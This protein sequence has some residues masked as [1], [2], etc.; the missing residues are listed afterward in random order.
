MKKILCV[1]LF[2]MISLTVA[3][4][5]EDGWEN[6]VYYMN[7]W[8]IKCDPAVVGDTL[9]IRQGTD[10]ISRDAFKDCIGIKKV[11]LPFGIEVIEEGAFD[12]T[13][14][15]NDVRNYKDGML[16]ERDYLLR[17]A[18]NAGHVKVPEEVMYIAVDAFKDADITSLSLP[19][20]VK[21]FD[22]FTF[23]YLDEGTP[24]YYDGDI[25]DFLARADFDL[26]DINIYT[27]AEMFKVI[28]TAVLLIALTVALIVACNYFV[29]E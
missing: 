10:G 18:P 13:T 23:E 14:Y 25:S 4:A 9:I 3:F 22:S 7:D 6:G 20:Y 17:V 26:E 16:I 29:L 21:N 11:E 15:I 5:A 19:R 2:V 1:L 12:G 27:S 8:A 24:V 28:V